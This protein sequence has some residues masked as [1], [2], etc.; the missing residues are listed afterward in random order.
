MFSFLLQNWL[1]WLGEVSHQM[2][3]LAPRYRNLAIQS[4]LQ[5]QQ[6]YHMPQPITVHFLF[7]LASR[8]RTNT[9]MQIATTLR[10]L[11][12]DVRFAGRAAVIRQ[13]IVSSIKAPHLTFPNANF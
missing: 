9:M 12:D 10:A 3:P 7:Y 8:D 6:V 4:R 2:S 13:A 1:V 5:L 11:R